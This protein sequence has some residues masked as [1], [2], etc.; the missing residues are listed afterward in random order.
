MLSV[1]ACSEQGCNPTRN[2]IVSLGLFLASTKAPTSYTCDSIY[3][4]DKSYLIY[5]DTTISIVRI[6]LPYD[7]DSAMI[8]FKRNKVVKPDTLFLHYR[9][10]FYLV[11]PTC[12]YD[13][14]VS[15]LKVT[16]TSFLRTEIAISEILIDA[17]NPQTHIKIY[18]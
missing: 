17:T 9:R 6:P 12:D 13:M 15:D 16:K 10:T 14:K 2:N 11:S 7:K 1:S 8:V 4:D 5:K 18:N 3:I